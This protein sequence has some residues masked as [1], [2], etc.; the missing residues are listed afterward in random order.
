MELAQDHP[1]SAEAGF[2]TEALRWLP[3]VARYA[4]LLTGNPADADDLAQET[5]LRAFTKW[6]TFR[7]GTDCRRWLFAICRHLYFRSHRRAKL[8]VAAEDPDA[9]VQRTAELFWEA[10]ARG[11]QD[12][13]DRIDVGPAIERGLREMAPEYRAVV[14]LI[15]VEGYSYADAA[16]A[17]AIPIGTV[18]SRL[19]R[20][21]RL[22]QQTL[23]EHARDLGLAASGV[24]DD[25]DERMLA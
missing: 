21:R 7:H 19:F 22:L 9:E 10:E 18:R 11:L 5:Y 24:R 12:L 4:R 6:T 15:D 16:V 14:L 1:P 3:A 8:F 2:R 25:S 17:M 23:I 20:A 13:F